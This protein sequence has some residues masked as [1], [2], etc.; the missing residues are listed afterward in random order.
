M[1]KRNIESKITTREKLASLVKKWRE[2]GKKIGF[3]S[4]SFDIIHAGHVKYLEKAKEMCDVLIAGVNSD[5]SV[6][7]YKGPDRPIIPEQQRIHMMAAL[8]SIDYVF[9]F[10][11]RRNRKN[12]EAI[13]PTFYIKAGDYK[14]E[15]LTSSSVVEQYGGKTVLLPLEEGFSTTNIIHK[16]VKLYGGKV[17][18]EDATIK[19]KTEKREQQ[20][21][22]IVDRDGTINEEVEYL[23]EPEKFLLTKN[24]GEGLKK[25]Q[26][27]GY[28]IVIATLQAGIGLGYFTKEDFF[29]V[30]R[31]MFRELAPYNITIDKIY[32]ATHGKAPDDK[33]PKETL[34]ERAREELDLNLI[35]SVVIGDKT[36]DI[37]AGV[38]HGCKTI[39]VK[40][41]HALKDKQYKEKPDYLAEDLLDAA[42]WL[43]ANH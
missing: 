13:Q 33:N 21:A 27:M 40:T 41:G 12:I 22:V 4:G 31:K 25:F 18:E 3:T 5:E 20:K 30:N 39:G 9:M 42:R 8:E 34:I 23:H 26:E 15:E 43:E 28:K 16:I 2:E 7:S 35:S 11:E 37:A 38:A 36:I 29:A 1:I 10:D 6:R 14:K 24:A 17:V 19:S 32:F